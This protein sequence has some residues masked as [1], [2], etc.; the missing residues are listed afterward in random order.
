MATAKKATAESDLN[1]ARIRVCTA[2]ESYMRSK[3][4]DT[5]EY[6]QIALHALHSVQKLHIQKM[7]AKE[8]KSG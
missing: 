6:L 8:L 5:M 3:S 2:A 1:A 4:V 7:Q